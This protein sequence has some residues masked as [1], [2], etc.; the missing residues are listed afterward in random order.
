MYLIVIAL[1][2]VCDVATVLEWSR[3]RLG[4]RSEKGEGGEREKSDKNDKSDKN[5]NNKK[6]TQKR[7]SN[8]DDGRIMRPQSLQRLSRWRP[9]TVS[10]TPSARQ[11]PIPFA[12]AF[13]KLN[14]NYSSS[15]L[16]QRAHWPPQIRS[17]A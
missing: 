13:R 15:P 4:D 7:E 1:D 8:S 6:K 9:S 2:K 12:Y 10:V 17:H 14:F 11:L 3:M 5:E 16:H